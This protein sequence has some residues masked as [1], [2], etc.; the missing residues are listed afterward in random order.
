MP[1]SADMNTKIYVAASFAYTDRKKTE[2]RKKQIEDVVRQIKT[3]A[4]FNGIKFDWYLPHTLKIENAWDISLEEWSR[5]VFEHDVEALDEA[6][7]IIFISFGKENNAGA[8]WEVGYAAAKEK[9]IIVVKMTDEPESL[10]I[11]NSVKT[12]IKES[13]IEKYNWLLRPSYM[14]GLD[15]LS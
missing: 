13:E 7:L 12:I 11:T 9:E 8:A 3:N 6:D 2:E 1:I 15:K 5:K 10:M 4:A 14:T